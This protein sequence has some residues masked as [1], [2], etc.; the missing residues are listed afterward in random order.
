MAVHTNKRRNLEP[1]IPHVKEVLQDGQW[2]GS[3]CVLIGGGPS[4]GPL[5]ERLVEFP[6][7]TKFAA[8]NQAWK[9]DPVPSVAYFIDKQVFALAESE[10]LERWE[11]VAPQQIR[12]TNRPRS[13]LYAAWSACANRLG[14]G[15]VPRRMIGSRLMIFQPLYLSL[16][17]RIL[18]IRIHCNQD[19]VHHGCRYSAGS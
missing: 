18:D 3:P 8:A 9:I 14:P 15:V 12:I 1:K 10:F 6:Q 7:G 17:K 4:L 5:L 11:K 16:S 2:S 13:R 19:N